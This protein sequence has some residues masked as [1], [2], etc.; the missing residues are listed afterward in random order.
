MKSVRPLLFL[1]LLSC[2]FLV[3]GKEPLTG[4]VNKVAVSEEKAA[5][6]KEPS[7]PRFVL[8]GE[9]RYL[10]GEGRFRA[11]VQKTDMASMGALITAGKKDQGRVD[12]K[13][14]MAQRRLRLYPSF[15]VN[16]HLTIHGMLE[17]RRDSKNHA[18]DHDLFL[19][20]GYLAYENR[21]FAADVGRFNYYLVDGNTIDQRVDGVRLRYNES[22]AKLGRFTIFKGRTV[23]SG[24]PRKD[25]FV[26][27]HRKDKGKWLSQIAYLD[28]KATKKR[29]PSNETLAS[30]G[31]PIGRSGNTYDHQRI[32][33]WKLAYSPNKDWTIGVNGL[34]S[35]GKKRAPSDE[36]LAAFGFPIGRSGNTYDH[37]R[38][39]EWK[40]AYSPNKDWTIGVNGLYSYGKQEADHYR[41]HEGGYVL[42]LTYG[43]VR[44]E[45]PG[46][47]RAWVRYYHQP[48]SS[49]IAHTMDGDTTFFQ[50]MGFQG[51]G[52][53]TD[54]TITKGLVW[55]LEGFS[56]KNKSDGPLTADFHE[57]VIGTSVM[58]YF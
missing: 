22:D 48:Q 42:S 32:G 29:A 39:G 37:Q 4:D 46:S 38:I 19:S 51:W 16:P 18:N 2:P 55:A 28:A 9:Y 43:D 14:T 47:F 53:R 56:L 33:E 52:L 8:H 57:Y 20:R 7:F 5:E 34:Y 3:H 36:T 6:G 13:I 27:E 21:S 50:R 10:F 30:F 12:K 35:Y 11:G 25:I 54:Y 15:Y 45:I 26:I 49:I 58:M 24:G 41:A 31:F 44:P 17:D 40:L 1:F 23:E